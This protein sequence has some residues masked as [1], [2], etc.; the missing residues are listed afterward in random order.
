MEGIIIA[1][2]LIVI[3][4]IAGGIAE[5]NHLRSLT[6]REQE[7]ARSLSVNNLRFVADPDTV[8]KSEMV[9]G[10]AVI[11]TDYFKTVATQLRK[12]TG[13]EMRNAQRLVERA[14]REALLRALDQARRIGATEVWNI[15]FETANIS[16][17]SG[18]QG[19]MQV[20]VLAWGT[21]IS[22]H[23]APRIHAPELPPEAASPEPVESREA[24]P[25]PR[26]SP[27]TGP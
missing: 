5:R 26:M 25:T 14:R 1:V 27:P 12:I 2:V 6:D 13:G 16:A 3:G 17:M 20:E 10:S 18:N 4:L 8:A 9:L 21:A 15:R 19:S 22:R 23:A 7:A 11:A 24:P